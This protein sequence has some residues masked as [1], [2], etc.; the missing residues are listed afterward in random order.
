MQA[1]GPLHISFLVHRLGGA[2]LLGT[3][4]ETARNSSP[5]TCGGEGGRFEPQDSN[6]QVLCLAPM[7]PP[8][9]SPHG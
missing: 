2:L 8:G 7:G 1:Y 4:V 6:H 3:K 9:A 5:S